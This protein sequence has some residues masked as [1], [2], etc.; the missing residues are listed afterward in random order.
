MRESEHQ[1]RFEDGRLAMSRQSFSSL[2]DV[3]G[4]GSGGQGGQGGGESSAESPP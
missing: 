4:G 1:Q 2:D 3:G